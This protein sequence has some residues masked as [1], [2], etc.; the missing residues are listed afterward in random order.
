MSIVPANRVDKIEF[1]EA[2]IGK[3]G[4]N[5][6]EIG[7]S[8]LMVGNLTTLVEAARASFTAA[9]AARAASKS[10]TLAFYEAVRNM[11]SG[12]GAGS[13]MLQ[14][15]RNFAEISDNPNV[16]VLANIP[17]PSAGEPLPPPGQPTDFTITLDPTGPLTLKCENAG[18]NLVYMVRRKLQG[19]SV[20]TLIGGSGSREFTDVTLPAG[21][22][23][24][25][26][27]ITAQ[28]GSVAGPAS[29]P[30]QIAFGVGTGPTVQGVKL[31]A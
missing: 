31:A 5:A 28:R 2:R 29:I 13:D 14:T 30:L 27:T 15:I 8:T 4:E 9:E 25:A 19:E 10:A 23:S 26:Y 12:P 22:D 21:V 24:V 17:A 6:V 7:L 11:H 20:W 1:Y 18:G 16:Y 3:W